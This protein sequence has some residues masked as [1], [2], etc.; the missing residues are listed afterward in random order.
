[1]TSKPILEQ[2]DL[3]K[4]PVTETELDVSLEYAT[5]NRVE[6]RYKRGKKK[7]LVK[8]KAYI[9]QNLSRDLLRIIA[10]TALE[11]WAG[12]PTTKLV[13]IAAQAARSAIPMYQGNTLRETERRYEGFK[14]ATMKMMNIRRV[15]QMQRDAERKDGGAPVPKRPQQKKHPI[16]ERKKHASQYRLFS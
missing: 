4:R 8:R 14:C 16:D 2:R 12:E 6:L 1:M 7:G 11:R 13:M 10:N 9:G 5:K 3:R 15:W